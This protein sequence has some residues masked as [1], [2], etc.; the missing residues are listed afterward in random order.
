[1]KNLILIYSLTCFQ[2]LAQQDTIINGISFNHIL[3]YENGT[4][5]EI[6]TVKITHKD[7]LKNG[8]WVYFDEAGV[9]IGKGNF[10]NNKKDGYWEEVGPE[11]LCCWEGIYKKGKKYGHWYN[12]VNK[13]Q[14][15]RRG[16]LKW[17]KYVTYK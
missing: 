16:K 7:T 12:G 14:F 6:G 8:V 5:K 11:N 9:Q 2:I 13:Q 3:T 4:I 1:M 17:E 15:Y 10:T